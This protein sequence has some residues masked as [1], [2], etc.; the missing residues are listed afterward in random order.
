MEKA[1]RGRNMRQFYDTTEMLAGI[2]H[3][4]GRPV[5]SKK[6]KVITKTEKP[7]NRWVENFK[8]LLNRPA[9]LNPPNI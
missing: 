6:D 9:P 1:A 4:P 3:K 8:K 7:R 5:K 2:Y